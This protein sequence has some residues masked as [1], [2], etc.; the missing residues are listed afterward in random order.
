MVPSS[1]TEASG[2][3]DAREPPTN[4]AAIAPRG[5]LHLRAY[6]V[7][8]AKLRTSIWLLWID[9]LESVDGSCICDGAAAGTAHSSCILRGF[10]H[11][12]PAYSRH[13]GTDVG[14]RR[15]IL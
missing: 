5:A 15:R 4:L 13:A 14:G 7:G 11:L 2:F 8:L 3:A 12:Q 1:I 10:D 6:G 9:A